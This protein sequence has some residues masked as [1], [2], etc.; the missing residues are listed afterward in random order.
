MKG[1][2]NLEVAVNNEGVKK[3]VNAI[4]QEEERD[5]FYSML[6]TQLY[7]GGVNASSIYHADCNSCRSCTGCSDGSC[8]VCDMCSNN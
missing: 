3:G 4:L 2:T 1:Q 7:L 8:A 5:V 6:P